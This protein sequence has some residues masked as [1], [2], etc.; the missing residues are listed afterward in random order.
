[1]TVE[2]K[3]ALALVFAFYTLS[4]V[5]KKKKQN[6]SHAF[7]RA[8]RRL[9]EFASNFDWL[10]ALLAPFVIGQSNYFAFGLRHSIEH[11]L[12]RTNPHGQIE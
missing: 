1:M 3:L 5:K 2:K 9:H 6:S 4:L 11:H 12:K 7:S 10:A 8:R